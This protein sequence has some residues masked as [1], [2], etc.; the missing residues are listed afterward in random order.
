MSRNVVIAVTS[1]HHC[2]STVALCPPTIKL[3]DGGTYSASKAQTWL[4]QDWN[5]YWD[6]V[7]LRVRQL[8]ADLITVF[9]GDTTD[10]DHHGT[11]QIISS[12]STAQADVVNACMEKVIK[13]KPD[14]MYFVRGTEAHV[15]KSAAYEERIADGLMKDGRPVEGDPETGT[16]SWWH[17]KL[18][19]NDVKLDFAHH[20]RMGQRPWTIPNVSNL[21][22]FQI[23]TEHVTR[24]RRHPDLAIRSHLHQMHD[25][26][27]AF[28]TRL[29][30]TPAWQLKTAYVH[31]VAPES[32]ATIGGIIITIS[33]DGKLDVEKVTFEPAETTVCHHKSK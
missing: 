5:E 19:V 6:R 29:I 9:N 15:G 20:G 31:K 7:R 22:A 21:L 14:K 24:K 4:W 18:M 10:G 27:D 13:S 2:G 1:D 11:S 3:D 28:P 12:N 30:Q 16:A 8:H 33:P 17:L 23:Y 32:L 25:T 26:Y